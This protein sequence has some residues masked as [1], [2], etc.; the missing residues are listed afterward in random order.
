M[1]ACL[2]LLCGAA[3]AVCHLLQPVLGL[4]P[5][6]ATIHSCAESSCA[7]KHLPQGHFEE[8]DLICDDLGVSSLRKPSRRK[9]QRIKYGVSNS[10]RCMGDAEDIKTNPHNRH[11]TVCTTDVFVDSRGA[12]PQSLTAPVA[13]CP[14]PS[15]PGSLAAS[16]GGA[17]SAAQDALPELLEPSPPQHPGHMYVL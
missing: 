17:Q 9:S 4:C 10:M 3:A 16:G 6:E 15:L 11:P 12:S 5:G 13:A 8:E 14:Y 1:V 7:K 2:L